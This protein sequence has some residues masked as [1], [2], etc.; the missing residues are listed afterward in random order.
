VK[1][2]AAAA[3][4]AGKAAA[5]GASHLQQQQ[6]QRGVVQQSLLDPEHLIVQ[7]LGGAFLHPTH[8][9]SYSRF[10]C[11]EDEAAAATAA[12]YSTGAAAGAR[13]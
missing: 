13:R 10:A 11:L 3:L 4:A 7:G 6:H 8:V 12:T 1:A 5:A 9:F 2:A